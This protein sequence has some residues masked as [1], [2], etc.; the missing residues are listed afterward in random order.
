MRTRASSLSEVMALL[1]TRGER[2]RDGEAVSHRE[3]AMQCASLA[4]RSLAT[5]AL[6]AACLLHDIGHLLAD[7][8]A[9]DTASG[10]GSD[11]RHEVLGTTWL[12]RLFPAAVLHP[13]RWHVDAKR[14]LVALRPAYL[15]ELSDASRRSL[16]WQGGP[17]DTAER[18]HFIARPFAR[19][20]L[21]LRAFDDAAKRRAAPTLPIELFARRLEYCLRL[22]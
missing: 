21:A 3:H 10:T 15:G 4:E 22:A 17:M 9:A 20:A 5:P 1:R 18:A 12:G 8:P 19:D 13:I 16:A 6:V 7:D 2:C 14:Y 11:D